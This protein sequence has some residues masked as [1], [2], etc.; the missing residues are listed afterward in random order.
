MSDTIPSVLKGRSAMSGVG[1][2]PDRK[3]NSIDEE[4]FPVDGDIGYG[5][6]DTSS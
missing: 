4:V 6:D 2:S 5:P 1:N 3:D